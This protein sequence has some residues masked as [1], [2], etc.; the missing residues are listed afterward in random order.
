MVRDLD[1]KLWDWVDNHF[2]SKKAKESLRQRKC[3]AETAVAIIKG[4]YTFARA[5]LRGNKKVHT[6]A[7]LPA[8]VHNIKQLVKGIIQGNKTPAKAVNQK[9]EIGLALA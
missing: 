7:W 2:Q 8:T 4:P 3:W 5:N 6:Q 1:E 9:M